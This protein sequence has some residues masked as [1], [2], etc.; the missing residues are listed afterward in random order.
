MGPHKHFQEAKKA[1]AK[2]WFL[3]LQPPPPWFLILCTARGVRKPST[4]T[5]NHSLCCLR[6]KRRRRRSCVS[7]AVHLAEV[8]E[9]CL[10][11]KKTNP[12]PLPHARL[13]ASQPAS[14]RPPGVCPAAPAPR[15]RMFG[16][17]NDFPTPS[18]P[19]S[20]CPK[21]NYLVSFPLKKKR[22]LPCYCIKYKVKSA[23]ISMGYIHI[24]I[25]VRKNECFT[26]E[27]R[28]EVDI[29]QTYAPTYDWWSHIRVY[30]C[31]SSSRANY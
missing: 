19:F 25:T 30:L 8:S 15:T 31:L 24:I 14:Q 10:R 21:G 20:N 6:G 7:G 4:S 13:P 2:K 23:K 12:D 27:R 28:A 18:A 17:E 5:V 9:A 11:R 3:R 29:S 16:L 26:S 1:M 22:E